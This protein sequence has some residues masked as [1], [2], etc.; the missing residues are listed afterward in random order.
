MEEQQPLS[1]Y[2]VAV[3][4]T[5]SSSSYSTFEAPVCMCYVLLVVLCRLP[6]RLSAQ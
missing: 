2:A 4:L 1:S 6:D 3:M 5:L